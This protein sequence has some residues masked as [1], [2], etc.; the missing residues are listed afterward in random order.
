LSARNGIFS[1]Q[2][3]KVGWTAPEDALL[4][5]FGYYHLY[6][7]GCTDPGILTK[8]LGKIYY[9]ESVFKPYPCCRG[10]HAS[11]DCAL[12]LI[13]N[14]DVKV[15][16][17]EEAVIYL[18]ETEAR[19]FMGQSFSIGDFPHADAAFSCRYTT[20]TALLKG[21]VKPEHFSEESIREP[22]TLALAHMIQVAE[23]PGA[24]ELSARLVLKMKDGRELAEFTDAPWG[25]AK[26][27]PMTREDII[28][29]YYVNIAYS[30]T[31]TM[32][33]ARRLL[34]LLVNLEKAENV[35]NI[36]GLL[37]P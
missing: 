1:A 4:S 36:I 19:A 7:S 9:T 21:C 34:D 20:A 30:K 32:D 25:D 8:D 2:L 10:T 13:R 16:D 5:Q 26:N 24:R 6:T 28:N 31:I 27:N 12:A 17:I 11:I 15:Q 14:Y 29:K 23:M 33:K 35:S 3:A 37:S 18:P 22:E